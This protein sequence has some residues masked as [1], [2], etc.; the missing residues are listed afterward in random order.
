MKLFHLL[1]DGSLVCLNSGVDGN[2]SGDVDPLSSLCN[3]VSTMSLELILTNA[4]GSFPLIQGPSL[5]SIFQCEDRLCLW[6]LVLR[7]WPELQVCL[8]LQAP[9]AGRLHN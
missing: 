1:G 6:V 3:E 7:F 2:C 4:R 5:Q 9:H 8:S